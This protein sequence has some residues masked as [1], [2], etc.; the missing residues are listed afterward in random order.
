MQ[1]YNFSNGNDGTKSTTKT[2]DL[3]GGAPSASIAEFDVT[4][5]NKLSMTIGVTNADLNGM[6]LFGRTDKLARWVPVL[7]SDVSIIGYGRTDSSVDIGT[8]PA[9]QAAVI[10]VDVSYWTDFKVEA[11]SAGAART[12]VT[13]SSGT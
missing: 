1:Q 11:T 12:S 3:A 6:S 7:R 9:G 10:Q 13:A 4:N 5:A 8:T 2:T